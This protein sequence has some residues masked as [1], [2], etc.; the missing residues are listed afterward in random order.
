MTIFSVGST[1]SVASEPSEAASA[2]S[3]AATA[4]SSLPAAELSPDGGD[5]LLADPGGPGGRLGSL[6]WR[7]EYTPSPFPG[8]ALQQLNLSLE[9]VHQQSEAVWER[10]H[11]IRS[12]D[13]LSAVVNQG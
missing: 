3:A 10:E 2:A 4:A 6:R 9:H 13:I 1:A 12:P 11:W 8:L 5:G 7:L